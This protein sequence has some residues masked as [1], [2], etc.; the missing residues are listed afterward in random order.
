MVKH[1][2]V[3]V[4]FYF[5]FKFFIYFKASRVILHYNYN[6]IIIIVCKLIII[7]MTW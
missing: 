6:F 4:N 1:G 2:L 7:M 5:A 3:P